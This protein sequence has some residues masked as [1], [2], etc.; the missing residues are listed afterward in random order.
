VR[1]STGSL[2]QG[3]AAAAGYALANRLDGIEARVFCLLG[4][5][6]CAEG[7]VWEA[8]Q[9]IALQ[10]LEGV[11]AIV[12]ANGLGQSGPTPWG[13]AGE[14]LAARFEAFGWRVIPIDG[15][16]MGAILDA[17][18][19]AAESGTSN[20]PTAIIARTVKGKGVAEIADREGWH[21]KPL[22]ETQCERAL[23][24]LGAAGGDFRVDRRHV[25][26]FAP[27]AAGA[28]AQAPAEPYEI[29][30]QVATRE[31]FGVALR[32]LGTS[33]Q[34]IVVLDADVSNSTYTDKFGKNFPER[35]VQCYI[36]EQA[37]AGAA[38][39]LAACGKSP[40]A[41]TFACFLTRAF[42]FIRMAAHSHPPR[43]VFCGSHAGVSIGEDGP[44]QMGLEDI[45]MFR[46]LTGVTVLSPCD[47]QSA[48]RLT[49]LA[50]S[51]SG[52]VYLRTARPKTPVIY[53]A[54]ERFEAGGS[55]VLRSS[56]D[57]R[58]TLVATGVTVHEALAAHEKL[59]ASGIAVRVLDAYSIAPLDTD[60][61]ERCA[62]D[63]GLLVT[64]EDHH[65]DGGLGDA[66]AAA[67][68]GLAPVVKLGVSVEPR[69]GTMQ[70][71]LDLCGISADAIERTVIAALGPG[72][73]ARRGDGEGREERPVA[74][75]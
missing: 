56:A 51:S 4:D 65:V 14:A 59:A 46:S 29:G 54:D 48:R 19:Q 43:L 11:V 38:L 36:A 57:D 35:F 61:L 23:A 60:T 74:A 26:V 30:A 16:D 20:A 24:A 33:M 5:G 22:D 68:S 13:R 72:Q 69:S 40:V 9:L 25:S 18:G 52:I 67:V 41:A 50:L 32:D 73:A 66:V 75:S 58:A 71:L 70:E 17:L 63:T 37:M 44:S 10:K 39:G 21:G 53:D 15:H 31:A 49:D 42:D 62:H 12:D 8:A 47:G 45:A 27:R 28:E 55:K 6:E 2:G 3:L 64:V 34:D 1:V 7:S